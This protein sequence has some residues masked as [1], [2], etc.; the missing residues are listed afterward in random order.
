MQCGGR[1]TRKRV[2]QKCA[3]LSLWVCCWL[4][5][6]QLDEDKA[7]LPAVLM[8]SSCRNMRQWQ[9]FISSSS[10]ASEVNAQFLP[11]CD[12]RG[13]VNNFW[14]NLYTSSMRRLCLKHQPLE[15]EFFLFLF[16]SYFQENLS[17][18]QFPFLPFASLAAHFTVF[19][20]LSAGS[21]SSRPKNGK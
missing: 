7:K 18:S 3:L 15:T 13:N 20:L 16:L 19:L 21:S 1:V 5:S 4:L 11:S 17:N 6:S 2:A 9:D 14:D 12:F 10:S 8:H